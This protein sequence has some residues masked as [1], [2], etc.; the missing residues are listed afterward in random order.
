MAFAGYRP[1]VVNGAGT[2]RIRR[3]LCSTSSATGI[4][5]VASGEVVGVVRCQPLPGLLAMIVQVNS[6]VRTSATAVLC[7]A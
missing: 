2:G 5:G 3:A 7:F 6:E 4:S 1:G